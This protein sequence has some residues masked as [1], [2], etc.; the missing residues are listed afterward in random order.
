MAGDSN[1]GGVKCAALFEPVSVVDQDDE[2]DNNNDDDDNTYY[3][4]NHHNDSRTLPSSHPNSRVELVPLKHVVGNPLNDESLEPPPPLESATI[5][6]SSNDEEEEDNVR[7][8]RRLLYVSHALAQG[9]EVAWQF[10][11]ALVL[12]ACTNYQSMVLVSTYGL[13]VN[14]AVVLL[15]PA[16]GRSIDDRA[17]KHSRL[18]TA[19][20]FIVCENLCV[21]VATVCCYLLLVSPNNAADS[22]LVDT[23]ADND[24]DHHDDSDRNNNWF[25]ARLEHVPTDA[26]SVVALVILHVTGAAAQVMDQAFLVAMERDWVVVLSRSAAAAHNAATTENDEATT[27]HQWLSDT[28]VAMKQIDLSC[29]VAAPAVVGL[30]IPMLSTAPRGQ[31]DDETRYYDFEWA[32]WGIGALNVAALVVEFVCTTRVYRLVP[33]LAVKETVNTTTMF[34][35]DPTKQQKGGAS[36]AEPSCT[37]HEHNAD[38]NNDYNPPQQEQ[39]CFGLKAV[40]PQGLYVYLQ[41][42]SAW[43]GLGLALLYTNSLTMQNGIMT[44]YLL[45][46]GLTLEVVGILRAVASAIGLLGTVV[47]HL[48]AKHLSLEATG[49]WSVSYQFGCLT[50]A[51]L[52][53]SIPNDD[54]LTLSLLIGC[55]CF[56]RIGLW[57][58]DIAVTQLQQQEV[59]DHIRG[60][61]GGVQ[62]SLNNG[63]NLISFL[64]GILFPDPND[65]FIYVSAG[66]ISVGTATGLFLFGVYLPRR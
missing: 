42:A 23:A 32:C 14:L 56:S 46:R 34:S 45:Y 2:E 12:A 21:L 17:S 36:K 7:R 53:L 58:Y 33:A 10:F 65:F 62:S 51:L 55:V 35:D 40:V 44:T 60:Q 31:G 11:L 54:V 47:Y 20:R 39:R 13:T 43:G 24:D 38:K 61:V 52:S 29:K 18:R 3:S 6:S 57:V 15:A 9:S 49:L 5:P 16:L 37:I 28:N 27:F 41:Q 1:D 26:P 19:R 8:A 66:V 4:S 48:S 63:F 25:R 30:L 59:P 64:L 22:Y 50:L